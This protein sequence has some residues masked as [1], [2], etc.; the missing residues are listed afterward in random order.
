MRG[1]KKQK[2]RRLARLKKK[3]RER[4]KRNAA[5]VFLCIHC[6]HLLR[7]HRIRSQQFPG[8]CRVCRCQQFE[9]NESVLAL[10]VLGEEYFF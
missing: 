6:G 9:L 3:L 10:S 4:Q 7:L 2:A 8:H 1:L 5:K